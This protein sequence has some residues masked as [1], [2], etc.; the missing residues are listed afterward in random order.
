MKITIATLIIVVAGVMAFGQAPT[1]QIVTADPNL[2]SELFY[3]NVKVKPLRVR[4]GTNPPQFITIDDSD[5]F[6]QQHYIDFLTRMPDTSGFNFWNGTFASCAGNAPCIQVQ[7]VNVSQAFFLSIEFK[8][9]GLFV[10]RAQKSA[11]GNDFGNDPSYSLFLTDQKSI[12]N[13][14]VVGQGNWQGQL[15]ANKVSYLQNVVSRSGFTSQAQFA[16]GVS[17]STFVNGLFTNAGVTNPPAA[18]VNAAIAAY[19]SGDTVGRAAA[20]QSVIE[21]G[22]GYNSMYNSS[23]VIM[24]YFGYLRRDPDQ[25][26]FNFWLTKVNSVSLPNED[27]RDDNQALSRVQRA[28]MVRAFIE[29]TEYRGRF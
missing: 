24:E 26:G 11:F 6:T 14:V 4:P 8:D 22:T 3:G 16:P 12:A 21:S 17:A 20:M 23:F 7:R 19:G 13:G 27:M 10:I 15:A 28:E 25:S 29:S 2:P 1:L 5:F 18:D 9:T